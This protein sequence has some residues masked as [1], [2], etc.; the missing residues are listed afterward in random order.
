MHRIKWL[1]AP[2]VAL[3][4]AS[5]PTPAL[6]HETREVGEFEFVVG[7]LDEPVYV[8][9]ESGL[10]LRVARGEEPIEGLEATLQAEVIYGDERR[11]L[12][13][14]PRFGEPGA[15]RSVF[16]PTAAGSYTFHLF[17]TVDGTEVDESFTSSP[18]GFSE[19]EEASS[20][21]FPIEFPP[22]TEL[23]AEA[24]RGAG[25]APLAIAALAV[26]GLGALLGLAAIGIALGS[27]RRSEQ[28]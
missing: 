13:I 10:D 22:H 11:A 4:L 6:G 12:T 5:I 20:A 2:A 14:S 19:V 25:A 15:Y 9:T 28:P 23:V 24:D 26:G 21:Q 8:G 3:A 16:F 1:I 18:E 7:F 17:G 27:R